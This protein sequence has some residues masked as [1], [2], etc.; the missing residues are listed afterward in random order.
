MKINF[1]RNIDLPKINYMKKM[2]SF[3]NI[4]M[5][6]VNLYSR[7]LSEFFKVFLLL[8]IYVL[9]FPTSYPVLKNAITVISSWQR[10]WL[11]NVSFK[12]PPSRRYSRLTKWVPLSF[13]F[14]ADRFDLLLVTLWRLWCA[15][16]EDQPTPDSTYWRETLCWR[17]HHTLAASPT[18]FIIIYEASN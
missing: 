7:T 5:N 8:S 14:L 12:Y 16:K 4:K 11:S 9:T 17:I 15:R 2:W 6:F 3:F 1:Y 13:F 18:S 10:L